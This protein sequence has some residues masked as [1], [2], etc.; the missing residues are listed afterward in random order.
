MIRPRPVEGRSSDDTSGPRRITQ[1][2]EPETAPLPVS[3]YRIAVFDIESVTPGNPDFRRALGDSGGNP[4]VII[5]VD[6]HSP[7]SKRS[8]I[9][10]ALDAVVQATLPGQPEDRRTAAV[11]HAVIDLDAHM[12]RSGAEASHLTPT[13][14]SLL[15]QLVARLN[16][17]VPRTALVRALW[18]PGHAKGAHSLRV[19]IRK[20]R[21]KIEPDPARPQYLV[22]E[23]AV[24]YRLQV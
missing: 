9:R 10:D 24:G 15:G 20:L 5:I 19:L 16:Q 6:N 21:Q 22:T 8:A 4:V 2:A 1:L 17:T 11:G 3:G 12:I 14:C 7:E 23:P 18:G 13:E